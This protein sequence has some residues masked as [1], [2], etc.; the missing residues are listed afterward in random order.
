MKASHLIAFNTLVSYGQS[1]VG[2]VVGL[3]SARWVLEALGVVDFGLFGLVGSI[4]LLINF[5]NTAMLVGVARFY[6]FSIGRGQTL[7]LEQST[8]DLKHLSL[9]H[10]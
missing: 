1:L 8:E 7:P 6:A 9:I 3:F 5:L 10:I 4:I 2:L